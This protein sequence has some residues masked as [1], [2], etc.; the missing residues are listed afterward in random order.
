MSAPARFHYPIPATR[1]ALTA[2][3]VVALVGVVWV[4]NLAAD[5]VI[6]LVVAWLVANLLSPALLWL[7]RR[8]VPTGVAVGLLVAALLGAGYGA[9]R[10][11][12]E[13]L[14][15]FIKAYPHYHAQLLGIGRDLVARLD[16]PHNP[17]TDFS[18]HG[19]LAAW[20]L[21]WSGTFVHFL[22]A[23]VLILVFVVFML[24]AR[25]YRDAKLRRALAPNVADTLIQMGDNITS[26]MARYLGVMS[27][28]G[29]SAGF[30]VWLVL[31]C[32]H[33]DFAVT[34][35]ALTV[36]LHFVPTV[37][38]ILASIP[39]ILIALVE[40]YPN[41][42]P[43]VFTLV[44]VLTIHQV[45]GNVVAP[46]ILGE[47]MDLNPVVILL[48]L[49]FWSWLWGASGALLS[50]LLT[51]AIKIICDNVTLLRPLGAIMAGA[52]HKP[53]WWRRQAPAAPTPLADTGPRTG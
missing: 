26:Q 38:A 18:W 39:P 34:W 15:V 3:A 35:G 27:V 45:I 50:V 32:L 36:V 7:V 20:V 8:R 6:P 22:T 48:A 1:A 5:I 21:S 44:A 23:L 53:R 52:P 4:L 19:K 51:A 46:L 14:L 17:I 33:V 12:Y 11:V 41:Y 49:V 43:A 42:W 29:L 30:L 31:T 37:G 25:P 40:Y 9:G 13:R 28:L 24:L 47:K 16:L 10:F 2:L